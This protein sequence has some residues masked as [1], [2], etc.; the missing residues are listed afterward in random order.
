MDAKISTT[1]LTVQDGMYQGIVLS[2]IKA[3]NKLQI[4]I[5]QC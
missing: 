4:N 5:W 1:G 3:A 2:M